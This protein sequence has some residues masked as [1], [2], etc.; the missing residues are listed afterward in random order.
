MDFI[1]IEKKRKKILHYPEK[2]LP[3]G[4]ISQHL[5]EHIKKMLLLL[6]RFIYE[7]SSPNQFLYSI[8]LIYDQKVHFFDF[9]T[10]LYRLYPIETPDEPKSKTL[11]QV[12]TQ[13]NSSYFDT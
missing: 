10:V 5:R 8:K 1:S 12:V 13:F 3:I 2:A 11:S 6:P 9:Q 7:V 4:S